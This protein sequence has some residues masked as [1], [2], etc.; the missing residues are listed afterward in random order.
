VQQRALRTIAPH[1]EQ[2]ERCRCPNQRRKD[3]TR[4]TSI[5]HVQLAPAFDRFCNRVP[6]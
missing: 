6:N 5:D 2:G 4:D 1:A 3:Q